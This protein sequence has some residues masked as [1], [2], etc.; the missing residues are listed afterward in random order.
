MAYIQRQDTNGTKATLL[1][2]EF[3]YDDYTAGGDTHR[4]YIGD[5]TT[6]YPLANKA[7]VDLRALAADAV[8]TGSITEEVAAMSADVLEPDDGTIQ[9][10]TLGSNTTWTDGVADGQS[11]TILLTDGD[12]YTLTYPTTTWVD[13]AAP[14]LTA[15]DVLV[16]FK[17]GSTLYAKYAGTTVAV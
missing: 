4:V 8:F 13:G 9:T 1:K 15:G 7:E 3:G 17:I 2:A 11:L 16:F 5:G 10:K 12:A 6:N 14:T